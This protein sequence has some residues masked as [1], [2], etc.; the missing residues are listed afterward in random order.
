M[1]ADDAGVVSAADRLPRDAVVL[2]LVGDLGVPLARAEP[3]LLAPMDLVLVVVVLL[4]LEDAVHELRVLLE[5]GP[6]LVSLFD[7]DRD[8]RPA[9]DRQPPCLASGLAA[10]TLAAEQLRGGLA[11]DPSAGSKFLLRPFDALAAEL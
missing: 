7:R 11:G 8:V 1:E 4:D 5:L 2:P 10:A 9:L 3:D 6:G